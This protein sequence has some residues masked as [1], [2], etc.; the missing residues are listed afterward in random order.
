MNMKKILFSLLITFIAAVAGYS[1]APQA[2]KYQ[3]VA[4]N[5][6]GDVVT[7]QVI[8]LRL[9]IL[10]GSASGTAVYTETHAP[11]AGDHGVFS[12]NVGAGQVQ[13]GSFSSINW[14][15]DD[16]WLQ[17]EMD[18][19]GGSN[20]V[21]MGASQ[22]LSVPY[23]LHAETV[24]DKDDADADPNN[25]I[26]T[27]SKNGNVV[28][29]SKGGG[30]FTD[31][32]NDA[33]ASPTNELQTLSL[34][35]T[36]ISL[37]NGNSI[38]LAPV[39]PPGGTDDQ[40][41][42]LNGTTL[43]IEDGNSVDL[44]VIQ[45]GVNDAD[46]NPTNELQTLS[47]NGTVISLSNGNSIDLGPVI[48]PGGTDDQTLS[49]NGNTLS[50]EDGNSVD[51]SGFSTP[52][53]IGP[54]GIDYYNGKVFTKKIH[55]DEEVRV[56]NNQ[57][58][59][60]V[61]SPNSILLDKVNQN[62][63]TAI[64]TADLLNFGNTSG[65]QQALYG[66]D[67]VAIYDLNGGLP[68]LSTLKP[69]ELALTGSLN[70]ATITQGAFSFTDLMSNQKFHG[71]SW[72]LAIDSAGVLASLT[73]RK[74]TLLDTYPLDHYA[75]LSTDSL[76]FFKANP[77]LLFDSRSS[78]DADVL[79]LIYG[80][81]ESQHFAGGTTMTAGLSSMLIIPSGIFSNEILSPSDNFTRFMLTN[82]SLALWNGA[83]WMN[84]WLGTV[85]GK[86]HGGLKL[87][88][89]ANDRPI[90]KL[91]NFDD[92][93]SGVPE[94]QLSLYDGTGKEKA[95]IGSKNDAG[96]AYVKGAD[97]FVSQ[98][99]GTVN[100]G[101]LEQL[102]LGND[103]LEVASPRFRAGLDQNLGS[104]F[105]AIYDES[106]GVVDPKAGMDVDAIGLGSV[107]ADGFFKVKYPGEDHFSTYMSH[108]GVFLSDSIGTVGAAMWRDDLFE[109]LGYLSAYGLNG[110]PVF[111]TGAS[112]L[113]GNLNGGMAAIYS[114]QGDIK[115][116]MLT[117]VNGIANMFL[118]G[119]EMQVLDTSYNVR[120]Y[121]SGDGVVLNGS[122][123]TNQWAG[124]MV[125]FFGDNT[126]ANLL[127]GDNGN[128]NVYAGPNLFFANWENTGLVSVLDIGGNDKAGLAVDDAG[129]GIVFADIKNF[130]M[131]DP[132]DP[133]RE[134]WYA[135]LEGP[136][137]AAYVRG[138][139]TLENGEAFVPFPEHFQSVANP[140]TMTVILTPMSADTYGLAVIEKTADG[141]RVKELKGGTGN[142]SFD[143]EVK[144]VR[145]GF[146]DYQP[147]RPKLERR[148]EVKLPKSESVIHK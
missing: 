31:E 34:N 136:E 55:S 59:S 135:S 66:R 53:N 73:Q 116:G 35:G 126:G 127:Y 22:L 80:T 57:P 101:V 96:V 26:Q 33:D 94:G 1:Q 145:A 103:T 86:N 69:A 109:S 144:C 6:S 82:D 125:R 24:A 17:V 54:L 118:S 3:A 48:P 100:A 11:N 93:G 32:V 85:N 147:V 28:T 30:S 104:G 105:M 98:L 78:L 79:K 83:K 120:T 133:S 19:G 143:W 117:D 21:L 4:R 129:K 62:G 112:W 41:L 14:G 5:A 106:N 44:S 46:A 16:Y 111:H 130:R 51:L 132:K 95:F 81:S 72:Y 114:G 77:G 49:L 7:N 123:G 88:S 113:G 97:D 90:V 122:P 92:N 84:A 23:A 139:A 64:A 141:I 37:S 36:V 140:S 71:S 89:G 75:E 91:G 148:M 29:L 99:D 8:G 25:E 43:S 15:A 107:Y 40:T 67:S 146:E 108:K 128:L 119:G 45:D 58:S 50:I 38:D 13:N 65:T 56:G 39:I 42:S 137:A 68:L 70:E 2:F 87:Y 9:S 115:A 138:T 110:Y 76:E 74:L 63:A 124:A 142:F 61:V 18:L 47:L 131:D 102:V 121:L 27:L 52:W 60:V 12:V 20:Y 134:I 10:K